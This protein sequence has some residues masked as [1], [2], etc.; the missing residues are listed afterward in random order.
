VRQI[1]GASSTMVTIPVPIT[2]SEKAWVVLAV[3]AAQRENSLDQHLQGAINSFLDLLQE[4]L[5]LTA[6]A[7]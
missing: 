3:D 6:K 7:A 5:Q 1:K 2:L 4:D